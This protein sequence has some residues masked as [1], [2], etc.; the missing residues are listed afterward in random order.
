VRHDTEITV[1]FDF[2]F[3]SHN[4]LPFDTVRDYQR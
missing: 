3:A 4:G 2:I 1:V